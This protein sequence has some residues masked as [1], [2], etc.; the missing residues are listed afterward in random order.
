MEGGRVLG[1]NWRLLMKT[2][3]KI[4]ISMIFDAL[5]KE[6]WDFTCQKKGEIIDR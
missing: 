2:G 1:K 6:K 3:K 5:P 4:M